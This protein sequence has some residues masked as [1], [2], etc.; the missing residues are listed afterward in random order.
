VA[1]TGVRAGAEFTAGASSRGSVGSPAGG[2]PAAASACRVAISRRA[3]AGRRSANAVASCQTRRSTRPC[4]AASRTI[5]ST[6]ERSPAPAAS[7]TRVTRAPRGSVDGVVAT[8]ASCRLWWVRRSRSSRLFL[9]FSGSRVETSGDR[10]SWQWRRGLAARTPYPARRRRRLIDGRTRDRA[11]RGCAGRGREISG[12]GSTGEGVTHSGRF[13]GGRPRCC[14]K[15]FACAVAVGPEM[16][17]SRCR[18]DQAQHSRR[19]G[20]P[21]HSSL[22]RCQRAS[23]SA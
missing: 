12:S 15:G 4:W 18:L 23:S 13:R 14:R 10:R 16:R 17:P 22:H 6:W 7:R 9:L 3:S 1:R 8:R 2:P 5:H 19:A 11:P 20:Q 21:T